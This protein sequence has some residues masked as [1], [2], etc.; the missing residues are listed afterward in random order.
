MTN[1]TYASDLTERQWP[2]INALLPP[3][4]RRGRPRTVCLRVVLNALRCS[5]YGHLCSVMNIVGRGWVTNIFVRL[6]N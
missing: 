4:Q 1:P 5:A 3:A 6:A 2:L